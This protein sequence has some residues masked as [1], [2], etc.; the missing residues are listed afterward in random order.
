[1]QNTLNIIEHSPDITYNDILMRLCDEQGLQA[2]IQSECE[3]VE[4]QLDRDITS[5]IDD[6]M[7]V[8]TTSTQGRY[9]NNYETMDCYTETYIEEENNRS[10]DWQFCN[11]TRKLQGA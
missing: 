5:L 10:M 2:H 9:N 4:E 7:I 3:Q 8:E 1:M 6:G 11:Y